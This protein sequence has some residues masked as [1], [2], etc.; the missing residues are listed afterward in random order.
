MTIPIIPVLIITQATLRHPIALGHK[1]GAG[2]L[3]HRPAELGPW[4]AAGRAGPHE[5]QGVPMGTE[6]PLGANKKNGN[7]IFV[8]TQPPNRPMGAGKITTY[9]PSECPA[10]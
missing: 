1:E 10:L 5:G 8:T 4:G 7:A 2:A 9:T 3:F 6:V